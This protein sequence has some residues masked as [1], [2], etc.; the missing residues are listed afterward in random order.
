[1]SL[2]TD[3]QWQEAWEDACRDTPRKAK[4][5]RC[6]DRTCG[7]PDCA[8]CFGEDSARRYVEAEEAKEEQ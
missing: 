7:G 2:L 6:G 8:S 4:V 3:E 1:M 5:Y